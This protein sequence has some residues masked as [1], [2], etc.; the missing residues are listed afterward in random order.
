MN[1]RHIIAD[2]TAVI[3]LFYVH[4]YT[5]SSDIPLVNIKYRKTCLIT[6]FKTPFLMPGSHFAG[7][8]TKISSRLKSMAKNMLQY[9]LDYVDGL[10]GSVHYISSHKTLDSKCLKNVFWK[11]MDFKN[12]QR[13]NVYP[14][15][16]IATNHAIS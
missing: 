5:D 13:F 15:R 1:Y 8:N 16:F 7:E 3:A 11:P 14:N 12:G 4:L 10:I 2:C 9:L 6:E